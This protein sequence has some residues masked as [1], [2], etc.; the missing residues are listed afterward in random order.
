[1]GAATRT[2]PRRDRARERRARR[3]ARLVRRF[4]LPLLA[5]VVIAAVVVGVTLGTRGE[6]TAA[7]SPVVTGLP[8]GT[9]SIP[10]SSGPAGTT[11][12]S[13]GTGASSTSSTTTDSAVTPARARELGA[14]ELGLI[15]VLMYHKIGYDIVPPPRLWQDIQQLKEAGFWPATIRELV[16]GLAEIPAGK[17][18]VIFTF[19]DSSPTH[20]R[21]LEDG[22]ID[23][24]SA[25]GIIRNAA[26]TGDW[27][28]KATFFPLIEVNAANTLFGQPEYADDKLRNMVDWGCEIGSHTLTHPDLSVASPATVAKELAQSQAKLEARIGGGYEV[29]TLSPP[30][31]EYPDDVSV[32]LSGEYEGVTYRY[33]AVVLAGGESG[34]SPF[35]SKFDPVRIPRITAYPKNTVPNLI[36]FFRSHPA[37]RYVSDGDPG[38]VSIPS[39][40]AESLGTPRADLAQSIV[41]Y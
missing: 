20:Y 15:P 24:D 22:S 14:N 9:G 4:L 41:R 37:L 19:D 34:P 31:G 28:V 13:A 21:I 29:F 2:D 36:G 40:A 38:T 25:M 30:Y 16:E 35:S 5:L 10:F 32:L 33:S 11:D 6:S 26:K 3:R 27:A 12:S 8:D 7:F 39:D 18:P 17:S 23:S 1:M